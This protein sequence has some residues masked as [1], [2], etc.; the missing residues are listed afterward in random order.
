MRTWS[1]ELSKNDSKS[2]GSKTCVKPEAV[3]FLLYGTHRSRLYAFFF[4]ALAR[5]DQCHTQSRSIFLGFTTVAIF[6]CTAKPS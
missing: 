2:I 4:Q 1:I 5:P 3:A 6:L